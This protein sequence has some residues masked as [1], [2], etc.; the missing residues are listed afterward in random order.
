M[1]LSLWPTTQDVGR[2]GVELRVQ[3]AEVVVDR[4]GTEHTDAL[5][6]LFHNLEPLR[7]DDDAQTLNEEDAAENRQQ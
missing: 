3:T 7:L 5:A 4:R 6:F 2:R 1:E